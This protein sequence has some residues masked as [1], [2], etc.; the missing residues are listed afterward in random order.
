MRK[1]IRIT[2]S[3]EVSGLGKDRESRTKAQLVEGNSGRKETACAQNQRTYF[4][5]LPEIL[6]VFWLASCIYIGK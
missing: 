2:R 4:N 6:G 1:L 3:G 5:V